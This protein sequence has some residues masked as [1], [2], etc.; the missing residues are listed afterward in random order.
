MTLKALL[1]TILVAMCAGCGGRT[2]TANGQGGGGAGG[3]T[4][5]GASAG[6]AGS[7]N[8]G[9]QA[10]ASGVPLSTHCADGL[11]PNP[12]GC[13]HGAQ[14]V[15]SVVKGSA[16]GAMVGAPVHAAFTWGGGM[17]VT[18]ATTV[19]GDGTFAFDLLLAIGEC[20]IAGAAIHAGGALFVDVDAN[21]VCDPA[22]DVVFVW[23][24]KGGNGGTC[25]PVP[26][27]PG[28]ACSVT[29]A[30]AMLALTAAQAV[31][32]A[33]GGCLAGCTALGAGGA[34]GLCP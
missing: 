17:V 24:A 8:V 9:G 31:C 10:G 22:T 33:I 21:G 30:G 1:A 18:D 7:S 15:G 20:D 6:A 19:A 3:S 28:A 34:A 16:F 4:G 29:A 13:K 14:A 12:P 32:P 25:A 27:M 5:S 11:P 2:G 23:T 26:V